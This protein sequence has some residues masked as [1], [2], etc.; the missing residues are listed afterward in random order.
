ME[1]ISFSGFL[2]YSTK[3]ILFTFCN[4]ISCLHY[5]NLVATFRQWIFCVM[6][7]LK[8]PEMNSSHCIYYRTNIVLKLFFDCIFWRGRGIHSSH[9]SQWYVSQNH[10]S[11]TDQQGRHQNEEIRVLNCSLTTWDIPS[12]R[13][14]RVFAFLSC[15]L[16]HPFKAKAMSEIWHSLGIALWITAW[17]IYGWSD[18]FFEPFM[19]EDHSDAGILP[20][21]AYFIGSSNKN[22]SCPLKSKL[23]CQ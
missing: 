16:A 5:W 17:L 7:F 3:Y 15:N 11:C 13:L 21:D 4:C 18:T 23:S 22:C 2:W 12:L 14:S 20:S 19:L 10:P 9:A 6:C 8:L 1:G